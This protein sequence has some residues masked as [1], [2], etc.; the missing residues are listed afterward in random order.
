PPRLR[1]MIKSNSIQVYKGLKNDGVDAIIKRI[2]TKKIPPQFVLGISIAKTNDEQNSSQEE[3]IKDYCYSFKRL[4]EENIGDFYTINISCPNAFGG[5]D[6]AKPA[7][8][9]LLLNELKKIPGTKP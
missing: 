8:L 4:N 9:R 2:K 5:E 3:G 7:S 1:R 6:F